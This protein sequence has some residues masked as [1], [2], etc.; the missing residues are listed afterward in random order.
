[1]PTSTTYPSISLVAF[2]TMSTISCSDLVDSGCLRKDDPATASSDATIP[3]RSLIPTTDHPR[4]AGIAEHT[5]VS[6][7]ESRR[8]IAAPNWL[9]NRLAF[10]NLERPYKGFSADGFPNPLVWRYD[11]D[12]GAPVKEAVSA[13]TALLHRVSDTER[14]AV[15]RGDIRED[16]EFRAWSNPELYVNPGGIRLDES[17]KQIQ[18]GI[19]ST[20]RA[21]LSGEGYMKVVG[22]TFT[23]HFLGE[24][25]GGSKVSNKHSYNFRL[26]LP[27]VDGESA[28]SLSELW[29]WSF[30]G[31]HLCLAVSFAGP[32]MVVAPTLSGAEPDCIDVGPHSGLRLFQTEEQVGLALMQS[33]NPSNQNR[34]QISVG[35]TREEGLPGDR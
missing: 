33:L 8:R 7:C 14:Q 21:S 34:A 2:D 4:I 10:D 27:L 17:T 31:H 24:L 26:F 32:R 3:F 25:V 30:F 18:D 12:E 28:P 16:D 29:G 6:W 35:M 13:T 1:M 11:D 23:N 20:M 5:A 22:C 15:V 9:I 19:H